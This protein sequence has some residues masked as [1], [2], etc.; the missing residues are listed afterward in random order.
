MQKASGWMTSQIQDIPQYKVRHGA[1]L[2]AYLLLLND[3]LELWVIR[4][5]ESVTNSLGAKQD[6]IIELLVAS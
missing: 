4:Q 1:A 3:L 5:M 2:N 6:G